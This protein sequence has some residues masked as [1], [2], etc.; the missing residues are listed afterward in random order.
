MRGFFALLF[1]LLATFLPAVDQFQERS[2]SVSFTLAFDDS[3]TQQLLQGVRPPGFIPF[4]K[5][6][7]PAVYARVFHVAIPPGSSVSITGVSAASQD[8]LGTLPRFAPNVPAV[9]VSNLYPTRRIQVSEPKVFR[10]VTYVDVLVFPLQVKEAGR[11]S[12]ARSVNFSLSFSK[13]AS[14]TS[15]KD[16]KPFTEL[17]DRFF[18]NSWRNKGGNSRGLLA[19]L[20]MAT[21]QPPAH[22]QTVY[23]IKVR[24]DGI[25]KLDQTFLAANTTWTLG[26]VDPRKLRLFNKGSEIPIYVSGEL[27]GT[28][29]SGDAVYFYGRALTGEN[30]AG[31]WEKGDFTDDNVYWL[32]VGTQNGLRMSLRDGSPI[33]GYTV[34]SSF[35]STIHYE[36]NPGSYTDFDSIYETQPDTDLWLW[37]KAT[38]T[39][40]LSTNDSSQ[41]V[42]HHSLTIPSISTDGSYQDALE[43]AGRGR[44]FKDVHPNHHVVVKVAGSTVGDFNSDDYDA[45]QQT[46]NF[47]QS[48]L[49][50]TGT[51]VVDVTHEVTDPALLGVD[52]D[53]FSSNWWNLTYSRKFEAYTDELAFGKGQGTYQFQIP[54]FSAS[55]VLAMDITNP[56]APVLV[57]NAQVNFVSSAYRITFEDNVGVA[58]NSYYA[59]V[60][61]APA[62]ADFI[63][64]APSNLVGLDPATNWIMITADQFVNQTE[65]QNLKSLRQSQG[66]N[67]QVVSVT[68][69]YDEFNYGI[70]SPYA[71]KDFL[72]YAYDLSNPSNLEYVVIL[73]DADYDYKDY[74]ADGNHNVVPTYMVA[75]PGFATPA[76]P[77]PIHSNE[78]YFGEF[79][80]NDSVPEVL[81]GRIP[82]RTA[83]EV[84]D[85]LG[86]IYFYETG[87]TDHSWLGKNLFAADCQDFAQFEPQQDINASYVPAA[88][89][90]SVTKMY[91]RL[92]PW[93]CSIK[94]A[95]GNGISDV[96]DEL[97][98]G[99][100]ITSWIGH[101]S[102]VQWGSPSYL[103]WLDLPDLTNTTMPTVMLNANCFTGMFYHSI[104]FALEEAALAS[105]TGIVSGFAPG[106][107]MFGFEASFAT[108]DFYADVF[109][110]DKVRLLGPLYQHLLM[111][112]DASGDA[113]TTQE[114]VA[115]GDPATKLAI[116][117]IDAPTNLLE[118]DS[119]CGSVTFDWD[120]VAGAVGYNVMR[121]TNLSGPFTQLNGSPVTGPYTDT[122]LTPGQ[123]Y[124]YYVAGV[125]SEGFEGGG[126]NTISH[127]GDSGSTLTITP[128]SLPAGTQ[129]SFYSQVLSATGGAGPFTFQ[130]VSGALPG[131]VTLSSGGTLSGTPAAT[132]VFTFGVKAVDAGDCGTKSY[133]LTI[134]PSCLFCDDFNDTVVNPNWTYNKGTWTEPGGFLQGTVVRKATAIATPAFIGCAQCTVEADMKIAGSGQLYLYGWYQSKSSHAELRMSA[135]NDYW[136]LKLYGG[137]TTKKKKISRV[138]NPNTNYHSKIVFDGTNFT[139]FIDGVQIITLPKITGTTPSGTVGFLVKSTTGSFDSIVVN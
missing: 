9:A 72:Q 121:S 76:N 95:S 116:P 105:Q 25:V 30:D 138:V 126:S 20:P 18:V 22:S 33:N 68:D 102:S 65:V 111:N 89:P 61:A 27:D 90:Y 15:V 74:A 97:N 52:I 8:R 50:G 12:L 86:K 62:V 88:S 100:A 36:Q 71:I 139:V 73:G 51:Q 130:V 7:S 58:G 108:E 96:V 19:P 11:I 119:G 103:H 122:G 17:Y 109:G 34:P 35:V 21:W 75:D 117:A 113:H 125:D 106:S 107:Y 46:F 31:V 93:S 129:G 49:G 1:L 41:A 6:G 26:T 110:K 94:D 57:N 47:S 124:Y 92:A 56:D 29:D 132:G 13:S 42:Q 112:L 85:T 99:Q 66:L 64:D 43:L 69:I 14:A 44:T 37:M 135:D 5:P 114:M 118:T 45:T 115:F 2:D 67:A 55:S 38:W 133:S 131:G 48:V 101:G 80:G 70:F 40:D 24:K 23:K 84:S 3:A 82:V 127:V 32:F 53:T 134:G 16:A 83:Q 128:A 81:I 123:T 4:G 60:P 87:I 10:Q 98:Q 120:T 39:H 59:S 54:G 78:N 63:L 104:A 77:W 79:A 137:G 28:L 91:F 136:M